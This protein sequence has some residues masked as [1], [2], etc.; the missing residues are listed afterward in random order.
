[1]SQTKQPPALP[2]PVA[3]GLVEARTQTGRT[4]AELSAEAPLLLVFLR[5]FG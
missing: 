1:M 2:A 4:L 3:A 5:H